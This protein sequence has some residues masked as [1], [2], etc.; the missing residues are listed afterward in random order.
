[1]IEIET[2]LLTAPLEVNSNPLAAREIAVSNRGVE[3]LIE[4]SHV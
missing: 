2:G 3:H 4:L 1:M